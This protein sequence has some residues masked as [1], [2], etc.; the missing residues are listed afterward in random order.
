MA[1]FGR[2]ETIKDFKLLLKELSSGLRQ[3]S[4]NDNFE[5]FEVEL[6]LSAGEEVNN[7]RNQLKIVPTSYIIT[8]QTGNG[9]I[10]AGDTAWNTNYISFKNHGSNSVTAKVK[11]LR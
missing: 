2:L 5:S 6:S 9:L 8:F 4:F 7:I 11:V 3:L 1:K 10:T